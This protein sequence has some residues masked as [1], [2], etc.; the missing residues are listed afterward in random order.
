MSAPLATAGEPWVLTQELQESREEEQELHLAAVPR[1]LP[2]WTLHLP[3]HV[4]GSAGEAGGSRE[5]TGM[6]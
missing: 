1:S 2:S 5:I 3:G 6:G 4:M